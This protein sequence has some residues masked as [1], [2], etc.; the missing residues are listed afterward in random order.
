M[1]CICLSGAVSALYVLNMH[2]YINQ[3]ILSI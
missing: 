1:S 2:M 3:C